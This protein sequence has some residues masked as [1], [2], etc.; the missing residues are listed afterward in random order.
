MEQHLRFLDK[1][2]DEID[3]WTSVKGEPHIIKRLH[4]G[5]TYIAA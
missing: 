5:E 3:K 4:V 1:D 2:G